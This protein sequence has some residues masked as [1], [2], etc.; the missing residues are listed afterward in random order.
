MFRAYAI[1]DVKAIATSAS[2]PRRIS[3]VATTPA[4]DRLGDVLD[5]LGA[6]FTN[7]IP[8]LWHHDK[9]RPI[10]LATLHPPTADGITF[11]ATIPTIDE[12]G[13]LRDRVD[14]AWQTLTAGLITGVSVGYRAE[15][16]AIRPTK[17]GGRQFLRSEICELSLV[18]VPA[19]MHATIHAIKSLDAPYLTP[20]ADG[21]ETT[22]D[23]AALWANAGPDIHAAAAHARARATPPASG[24]TYSH[25]F[26]Y[27]MDVVVPAMDAKGHGPSDPKAF[28]GWWKQIHGVPWPRSAKT[29]PGVSGL[30]N[31]SRMTAQE[32]VTQFE[33]SRAAKVA[34]MTAIMATATDAT[35]PDDKKE[36]YDGLALEVKGLDEHLARARELER[37]QAASATR[38]PATPTPNP[39]PIVSIKRNLPPGT[40]FTRAAM[41]ILATGGRYEA[42]EYA[43]RWEKETPEVVTYL[44][45]PMNPGTSTDPAW[46]GPLAVVQN[47]ASEFIEL[48]RPATV[49]GKIPGFRRIPFNASVPIQTAGGSYGWVGQ[50]L[51]KSVTSLAFSSAKL[52]ISKAAGIVVL[53]EELVRISTPSAEAI[54]QTDMIAGIAAFLDT[55]FIDPTVAYLANVHP[56]SITNG[57]T[58]IPSANDPYKDLLALLQA[59]AANNVPLAGATLILSETNA[60]AMAFW[61]DSLGNPVFPGITVTG[62]EAQGIKVVTSKAAGSNVI[63]VYPPSILYADDGGVTIDVS[64]EASVQMDSAP[65]APPTATTVLVSLWQNNLVGLRAERFINW[66][67]ALNQGVA[68]V[69]GAAYSPAARPGM[70]DAGGDSHE[71]APVG[72]VARGHSRA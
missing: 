47:V 63:L 11:D 26:T 3:G 32:Q 39:T 28:C 45:A 71:T 15:P 48:L 10:G 44:K 24:G 37:L 46:A 67:R 12:P 53:T 40:A 38:V 61:R 41:A 35:L 54:V 31:G 68:L 4:P 60:L 56:A 58:G 6:T 18:T 59:F 34:A 20:K 52:E 66:K 62:G 1:L 23:F 42:I 16:G 27:C 8:L 14:E 36:E 25:A 70:A 33:N 65:D 5:P 9:E 72:H 57:L 49:L 30:S 43:K 64:R 29:L 19:N 2:T 7:P 17:G 13:A 51:A 22:D 50:G 55:Q 69:T 21:V